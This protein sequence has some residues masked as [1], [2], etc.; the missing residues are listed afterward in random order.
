LV[1]VRGKSKI[2]IE[3][4]LEVIGVLGGNL[5]YFDKVSVLTLSLRNHTLG[6]AEGFLWERK[7]K[8]VF[9]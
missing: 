5:I 6:E 4:H 7:R 2:G 3:T 8:E 9:G 1:S